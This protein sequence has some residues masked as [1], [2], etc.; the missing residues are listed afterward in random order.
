MQGLMMKYFVLKPAGD[1]AY[2]EA[3]R[4][5]MK[6]YAATIRY[7]D[8]TLADELERWIDACVDDLKTNPK[9]ID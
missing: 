7:T 9:L 2:A 5:A 4:E 3:S 8:A 6:A 1:D